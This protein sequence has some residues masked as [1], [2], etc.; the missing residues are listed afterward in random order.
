MGLHL[1]LQCMDIKYIV[2][3]PF[4]C[5]VLKILVKHFQHSLDY[6]RGSI[7]TT[8]LTPL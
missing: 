5:P 6:D 1:H 7:E 8:L 2:S 4:H 3:G